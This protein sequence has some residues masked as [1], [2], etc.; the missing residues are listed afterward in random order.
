MPVAIKR[1]GVIKSTAGIIVFR[2]LSLDML[3]PIDVILLP[4]DLRFGNCGMRFFGKKFDMLYFVIFIY[5]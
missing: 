1:R 2:I 4:I 5:L 3:L